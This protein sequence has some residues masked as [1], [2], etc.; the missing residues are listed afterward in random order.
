M[1]N[2]YQDKEFIDFPK[3]YFDINF[4]YGFIQCKDCNW[5]PVYPHSHI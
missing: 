1:T 4:D 5:S 3:K 2:N